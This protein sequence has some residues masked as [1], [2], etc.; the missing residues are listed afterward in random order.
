VQGG[1]GATSALEVPVDGGQTVAISCTAELFEII[2]NLP[3]TSVTTLVN[4]FDS[5]LLQHDEQVYSKKHRRLSRRVVVNP[6]G[7]YIGPPEA[8]G[9]RMPCPQVAAH[10]HIGNLDSSVRGTPRGGIQH[11][12]AESK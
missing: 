6:S 1:R 2:R 8:K 7:Q 4:T 10:D 3:C 12:P 11:S 9:W 5:R